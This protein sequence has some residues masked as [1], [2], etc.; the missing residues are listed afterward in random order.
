MTKC[1]RVKKTQ[2]LK[3][4]TKI[5]KGL[6]K[7]LVL[8]QNKKM[9]W[10]FFFFISNINLHYL[11][12]TLYDSLHVLLHQWI[13]IILHQTGTKDLNFWPSTPPAFLILIRRRGGLP[14]CGEH[15][16]LFLWLARTT[17][18]VVHIPLCTSHAHSNIFWDHLDQLV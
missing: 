15:W 5:H 6:H 13:S 9:K 7:M 3:T 12:T 2:I 18:P 1:K 17:H 4:K 10:N 11:E 16:F 8:R 14:F